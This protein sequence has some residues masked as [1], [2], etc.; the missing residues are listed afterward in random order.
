VV[1]AGL[2]PNIDRHVGRKPGLKGLAGMKGSASMKGSADYTWSPRQREFGN[3]GVVDSHADSGLKCV[4]S[5]SF[6]FDTRTI[7]NFT[8]F[9]SQLPQSH[10]SLFLLTTYILH[11]CIALVIQHGRRT[12]SV[13]EDTESLQQA[14]PHA[15]D[16]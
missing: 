3:G 2:Y 10:A 6:N 14:A 7:R 8:R 13:S 11:E 5:E 4:T 9:F 12:I 15:H 16:E 1:T